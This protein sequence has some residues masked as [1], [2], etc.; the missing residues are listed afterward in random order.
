MR[1]PLSA[2]DIYDKQLNAGKAAPYK[3]DS[4]NAADINAT[5]GSILGSFFVPIA[6]A[7]FTEKEWQ[8]KY[9][10]SLKDAFVRSLNT[11]VNTNTIDIGRVSSAGV[12]TPLGRITC[13]NVTQYGVNRI[14]TWLTSNLDILA[15]S[16]GESISVVSTTGV[17]GGCELCLSF[18]NK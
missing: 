7:A 4:S 12:V 8:P 15:L 5:F 3:P 10:I 18:G 2:P 1:Q 11:P 17:V 6:V 14:I 13:T 9:D 16:N